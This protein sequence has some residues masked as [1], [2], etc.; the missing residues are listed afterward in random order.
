M[1]PHDS[2]LTAGDT[3]TPERMNDVT[4][5]TLANASQAVTIENRMGL[6]MRPAFQFVD[7]ACQFESDILV[8]RQD[9][10][11]DGKHA[12]ELLLLEASKGSSIEIQANGPDAE[13]AVD[14]LVALVQRQFDIKE[15]DGTAAA[16]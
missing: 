9:R 3:P 8:R 5:K 16:T 7:M 11:V 2:S 6:H 4:E 10:V 1:D 14:D 15:D 12:M 13:K